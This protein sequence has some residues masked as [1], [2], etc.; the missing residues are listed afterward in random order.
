MENNGGDNLMPLKIQSACEALGSVMTDLEEYPDEY[1][2]FCYTLLSKMPIDFLEVK[3]VVLKCMWTSKYISSCYIHK[4]IPDVK[5]CHWVQSYTPMSHIS[6][7][8]EKHLTRVI[9]GAIEAFMYSTIGHRREHLNYGWN[10]IIFMSTRRWNENY[11]RK[12]KKWKLRLM[13]TEKRINFT[14]KDI[15]SVDITWGDPINYVA[16]LIGFSNRC[17]GSEYVLPHLWV[18]DISPGLC[19][20]GFVQTVK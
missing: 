3:Q 20:S 5:L 15:S 14:E 8:P 17:S 10:Q 12:E 18:F 1:K 16:V 13:A 7:N 9:F 2:R 11:S 4:G 19:L 6:R